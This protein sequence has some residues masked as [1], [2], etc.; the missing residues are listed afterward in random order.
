MTNFLYI[1]KEQ[2]LKVKWKLQRIKKGYSDPDIWDFRE[3][4]T[5]LLIGGLSELKHNGTR[6]VGKP[7][8]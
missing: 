3:Y 8:N 4:L 6:M 5:K 2:F 7:K 1:I